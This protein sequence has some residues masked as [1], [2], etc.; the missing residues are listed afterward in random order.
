M[1]GSTLATPAHAG[2]VG[3]LHRWDSLSK[4]WTDWLK[5]LLMMLEIVGNAD[6]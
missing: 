4:L 5:F 6:Q 3:Q 1:V 2:I